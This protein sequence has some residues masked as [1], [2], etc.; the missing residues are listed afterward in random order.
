MPMVR[1]MRLMNSI[2]AGSTTSAQLQQYLTNGGIYS[3][4]SSIC[5]LPGQSNVLSSSATAIAAINGSALASTIVTTNSPSNYAFAN[6][7]VARTL[8]QTSYRSLLG[9]FIG[10]N[11]NNWIPFNTWNNVN[12]NT[13]TTRTFPGTL[14]YS[15]IAYG[16]GIFISVTSNGS[17]PYYSTDGFNWTA[18]TVLTRTDAAAI[19]FGNIGGTNYWVVVFGGCNG[20]TANTVFNYS[21]NNGSTWTAGVMPSSSLW[22]TIAFANNTFVATAGGI[23]A[24]TST[25]YSTTGTTFIAG[26]ALPSNSYWT[27]LAAGA[28]GVTTYFV[29]IVG[30]QTSSSAG[31]YSSNGGVTWTSMALPATA[32]WT[33]VAYGNQTFVAVAGGSGRTGTGANTNTTSTAYSTNG[34][35]WTAGGAMP[36]SQAWSVVIYHNGYFTALSTYAF[37]ASSSTAYSS[38][39]GQ[40]WSNPVVLTKN[41]T[42]SI[43]PSCVA[44]N[45]T[46]AISLGSANNYDVYATIDP[47]NGWSWYD[48]LSL[49]TASSINYGNGIFVVCCSGGYLSSTDGVNWTAVYNP[50]YTSNNASLGS[51]SNYNSPRGVWYLNGKWYMLLS[52]TSTTNQ[53]ILTSTDLNTWTSINL[54]RADYWTSISNYGTNLVLM[55]AGTFNPIISNGGGTGTYV[56]ASTNNGVSFTVSSTLASGSWQPAIVAQNKFVSVNTAGAVYTASVTTPTT[57]FTTGS[58]GLASVP[59][60]VA[61]GNGVYVVSAATGTVYWASALGGAFNSVTVA[62]G[63]GAFYSIIFSN[64]YFWIQS[65]NTGIIYYSTN[66]QSWTAQTPLGSTNYPYSLAVGNNIIVGINTASANT[67]LGIY[68]Q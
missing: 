12:A 14:S 31:A 24:S 21:T 13:N 9:S 42:T 16:N 33:C 63:A 62:S 66:G 54:S 28:I 67:S 11:P 50:F 29:A 60:G 38:D 8:I 26:G 51:S 53:Y 34:T 4:F 45:G 10:A 49:I 65:Y 58:S 15:G 27:S 2:E 56:A 68:N 39:N 52:T 30:S 37:S 59:Y 25:A 55:P 46:T 18:R 19:A 48:G 3:D 23:T 7:S 17:T 40:S 32:T 43:Y 6:N 64:G 20:G 44:T 61:Y 57:W 36:T 5:Q 47:S 22:N 41:L 1:A 35:S